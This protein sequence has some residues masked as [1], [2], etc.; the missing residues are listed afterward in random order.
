[1]Y[2][3]EPLF[4]SLLIGQIYPNLYSQH[5]TKFSEDLR[6]MCVWEGVIVISCY[7]TLCS[8]FSIVLCDSVCIWWV[9]LV[10]TAIYDMLCYGLCHA[11]CCVCTIL[12]SIACVNGLR[13]AGRV[14]VVLCL[15]LFRALWQSLSISFAIRCCAVL[16]L[17]VF[18]LFNYRVTWPLSRLLH[19]DYEL[20]RWIC[21]QSGVPIKQ[22]HEKYW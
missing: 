6:D 8:C 18:G 3:S 17:S 1:M 20:Y 16:L 7:V 11:V 2:H 15:I 9:V 13:F 14:C 22:R 4:C 10:H 12:C 5:N 21:Q 19:G